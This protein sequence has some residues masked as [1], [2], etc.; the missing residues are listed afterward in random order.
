[1]LER[2][3]QRML[4]PLGKFL[5]IIDVSVDGP[6]CWLGWGLGWWCHC[7][8]VSLVEILLY[9]LP[10]RVTGQRLRCSHTV[11]PALLSRHHNSAPASQ[12]D[13]DGQ[14]P[15]IWGRKFIEALP[16]VIDGS[17]SQWD[18]THKYHKVVT[19]SQSSD[20]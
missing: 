20:K 18:L 7:N 14:G 6:F 9:I 17:L 5:L 3:T 13:C 12:G 15:I 8:N 16:E 19:N 1:M 2:F 11:T 10:S 4:P